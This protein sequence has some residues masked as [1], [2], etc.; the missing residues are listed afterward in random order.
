MGTKYYPFDSMGMRNSLKSLL[1]AKHHVIRWQFMSRALH[2]YY[3]LYRN[4]KQCYFSSARDGLHNMNWSALNGGSHAE[5]TSNFNDYNYYFL[6][7]CPALHDC[8]LFRFIAINDFYLPSHLMAFYPYL[9]NSDRP[10]RLTRRLDRFGFI[11]RPAG[12]TTWQNPSDPA[13]RPMT[14]ATQENPD[15]TRFFFK[16]GFCDSASLLLSSSS[17]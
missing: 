13:G 8:N 15:E 12:A 2:L 7:P 10:G 9:L 11:K 16:C 1:P 6:I 17:L 3:F 4:K 14:R 5:N